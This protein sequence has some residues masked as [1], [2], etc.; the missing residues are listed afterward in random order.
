MLLGRLQALWADRCD[1]SKRCGGICAASIALGAY[2]LYKQYGK[3]YLHYANGLPRK[4]DN[5]FPIVGHISFIWLGLA[6][7]GKRLLERHG[8][9]F[10]LYLFGEHVT[11]IDWDVYQEHVG[12]AEDA[13]ELIP[14]W[15]AHLKR[16]LGESSIITLRAGRGAA[17]DRHRLV[18]A[19]M[20]QAL[21][22]RQV[23]LMAQWIDSAARRMLDKCVDETAGPKG[24]VSMKPLIDRLAFENA[25]VA[26]LGDLAEDQ[27][28]LDEMM[29]LFETFAAGAMA[30]IPIDMPIF[31]FGRSM[32]ARRELQN[33]LK[34]LLTKAKTS[35]SR[36]NV[37]AQLTAESTAG[38]GLKED[39][40]LDSLA[41][42]L[43]AGVLT[44]SFT[45]PHIIVNL[46]SRPA[47]I[48]KIAAEARSMS[49]TE[50]SHIE[51]PDLQVAN[52][53]RETM[54]LRPALDV[55]RRSKVNG[56][57]DLGE[58]GTLPAGWPV[59]VFFASDGY[60]KGDM[61]DPSRWTPEASR[62]FAG[63][64]GR[65]PH[66]CAGKN[67]ALL[68]MEIVAQVIATDYQVKVLDPT[69]V[70]ELIG[71]HYKGGLRVQVTRA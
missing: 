16:L 60:N 55:F 15:P 61:F 58:Y 64:G 45:I 52:F 2:C 49:W 36:R 33:I 24:E 68:E 18:K 19:K 48:E 34:S 28:L 41:T 7:W 50:S 13:G 1:G 10:N 66:L 37:L 44:T 39:E 56:A 47:W 71:M 20:M 63:F 9:V 46:W 31:A 29:P 51:A 35:D 38:R 8:K 42:V 17:C 30:L 43:V 14:Q 40:I 53:V 11:C 21:A 54:R 22:P 57:L 5:G 59:A 6:P 32:N 3:L 69:V 27:M 26:I 23:L 12:K 4:S 70:P 25:A 62:D 67:L 65:S